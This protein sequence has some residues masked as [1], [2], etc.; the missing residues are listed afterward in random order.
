M[1][2]LPVAR[3]NALYANPPVFSAGAAGGWAGPGQPAAA[4]AGGRGG[5]GGLLSETG[6]APLPAP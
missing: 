5:A 1:A 2:P 4:A 3:E 6:W